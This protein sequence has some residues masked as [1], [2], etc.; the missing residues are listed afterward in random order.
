MFK[1]NNK[2]TST[3]LPINLVFF[4]FFLTY[5]TP[6]SSLSNVDFEHVNVSRILDEIYH[7]LRNNISLDDL[8]SYHSNSSQTSGGIELSMTITLVLQVNRLTKWANYPDS[9]MQNITVRLKH[10]PEVR[11]LNLI[12]KQKSNLHENL[13]IS[14][15]SITSFSVRSVR[16][17][18]ALIEGHHNERKYLKNRVAKPWSESDNLFGPIETSWSL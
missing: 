18:I 14:S 9:M 11:W 13:R 16:N 10:F 3:T 2:N 6:F 12:Q 17:Y 7:P 1:V 4:C 8:M 5:F 15:A